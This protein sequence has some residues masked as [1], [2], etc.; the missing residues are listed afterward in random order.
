MKILFTTISLLL[1]ILGAHVESPKYNNESLYHATD[2]E[3]QKSLND[4]IIGLWVNEKGDRTR[5]ITKCKISYKGNG[6]V[7]RMWGACLP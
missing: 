7:V 3:L 2:M 4:D 6:L 5:S 1:L